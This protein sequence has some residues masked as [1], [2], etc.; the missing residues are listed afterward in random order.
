MDPVF[1]EQ[2]KQKTRIEVCETLLSKDDIELHKH[3]TERA[4][5]CYKQEPKP[6]QVDAVCSLVRGNN[7]FVLAGT[8][9]G[10]TCIAELYYRLFE[11]KKKP[12]VLVLNPLDA[13]G[14][15]QV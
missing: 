12:V 11:Q 5:S 3:I 15:N 7:T 6:R 14:D 13:L 2:P 4:H 8:G 1:D 9:F 10:K